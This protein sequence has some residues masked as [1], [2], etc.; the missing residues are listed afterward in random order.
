MSTDDSRAELARNVAALIRAGAIGT[1]REL[2]DE[3]EK[4]MSGQDST[5]RAVVY[6]RV[7]RDT[8]ETPDGQLEAVRKAAEAHGY[9]VVPVHE[10]MSAKDYAATHPIVCAHADEDGQG[11]HIL[12][13]G[14]KCNRGKS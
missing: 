2:M 10:A 4:V 8:P 11:S 14:E 5:P 6:H 13:P 7:A 12:A 9:E 3:W 1:A